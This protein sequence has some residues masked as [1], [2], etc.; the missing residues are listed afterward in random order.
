MGRRRGEIAMD[1]PKSRRG[2]CREIQAEALESRTLLSTYYVAPTGSDNNAGM[3]NG[4]AFQTLQHAANLVKAGDTVIVCAG[5][6]AGFNMGWDAP[7]NGTATAPIQFRADPGATITSRNSK[8]A[9][10]I[11]LEAD[12]YAIVEG[13]AVNNASGTITRAGIRAVNSDH[14]Q[15]LNNDCDHNGEWGIFT[16]FTDDLLL[17]GN[18]TSNSQSQHGIYVSNSSQRPVIRDNTSFGNADGGIQINA[19][20]SEGGIGITYGALIEDNIIYNNDAVGGSGINLDGVQNS[21]IQNNLLYN[22]H[23]SGISLFQEDGAAPSSNNLVVNNTIVMASNAR[24][25]LNIQD[26]STGNT[27]YNNILYDANPSHGAIDISSDSLPGFTSDYNATDGRFTTSDG[28]TV[29][30]LA[31]WRTSTGQ[32]AHSFVST[33]GALFVNASTNDYRLSS[34]SPA[35]DAGT[36][37]AAPNDPPAADIVGTSRPQGSRYDIGAYESP[38]SSM[39]TVSDA[40]SGG[41]VYL[42]L[43]SDG[44]DLDAWINSSPSV[45]ATPTQKLPISG[46]GALVVSVAANSSVTLDQ[47]LG[48]FL[49][50]QNTISAPSSGPVNIALIGLPGDDAISL[51][52]ASVTWNA[53]PIALTNAGSLFYA[54]DGGDDVIT[55]STNAVPLA[56]A[57]TVGSDTV[58]VNSGNV[59]LSSGSGSLDLTVNGGSVNLAPASST[60]S[61]GASTSTTSSSTNTVTSTTNVTRSPGKKS[62]RSSGGSN[63]HQVPPQRAEPDRGL[64]FRAGST[65]LLQC[66]WDLAADARLRQRR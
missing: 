14:V 19:D 44:K 63:E 4:A 45:S 3:S 12:D 9:D 62:S 60:T 24:W 38:Q 13:F 20:G 39:L 28:D 35:I 59:T 49:L 27:V 61:T 8:T 55:A 43:D 31:Q 36:A 50:S 46:N 34:T 23:A 26:A 30:T 58:T 32:D 25:A 33:P 10:G 66:I 1:A 52:D 7:Q 64:Q 53:R 5:N 29:L 51:G 17:Q 56:I 22:N 21:R 48:N 40:T 6:Y 18:T 11:D 15:L 37:L 2:G 57:T 65:S 16:G 54:D 42:R 47:S 41:S